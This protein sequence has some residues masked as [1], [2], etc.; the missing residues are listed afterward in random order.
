[1][2]KNSKITQNSTVATTGLNSTQLQLVPASVA[3][4]DASY[5]SKTNANQFR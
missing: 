3:S 4:I 2:L 5:I 1:M